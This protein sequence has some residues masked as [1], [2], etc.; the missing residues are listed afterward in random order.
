MM[1]MTIATTMATG[2][3]IPRDERS[4]GNMVFRSGHRNSTNGDWIRIVP[5]SIALP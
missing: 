2:V 3:P 5:G 4:R 1:P